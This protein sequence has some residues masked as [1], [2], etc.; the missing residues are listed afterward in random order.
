MNIVLINDNAHING[1]AAKIAIMNAFDL[2]GRGHSVFFLCALMP[3]ATELIHPNIK[4]ICTE[5]YEILSDP[6]RFRASAQGWW[7]FKA[8]SVADEVFDSLKASETVV[9]LHTW[10]KA[11]SSSVIRAAIKRGFPIVCTL[12]DFMLACPTGTLFNHPKQEICRLTPMSTACLGTQCDARS[13]SQKLWRVGRQLIQEKV[14]HLPRGISNFIVHSELVSDVMRPH[15][16][17]NSTIHPVP[18]YFQGVKR[19]PSSP[20]DNETFTYLGRLVREKGV[21]MLARSAAAE[22]VPLT[23]V[24]SGEMADVVRAIYPGAPVTGWMSREESVMYLRSSRAL[25]FPSLWYETLGL[26]VLEASANGIPSIVPRSSAAA[27]L[28]MDGETGLHFN[29]GDEDDLRSKIRMLK[30]PQ[31][32]SRLGKAAYEAFWS[33]RSSRR[34]AHL[35]SLEAVYRKALGR[36]CVSEEDKV[37]LWESS[38]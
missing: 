25:V 38:R 19:E 2:A 22:R 30:N 31:L 26:V 12:H 24:G 9:H 10:A 16:P 3:V 13:Y 33:G 14:G 21:A 7:N 17:K 20:A 4:V 11:L 18:S 1:G 34:G 32:A 15:L 35:D 36:D 5:Q 37:C 28:V 23:F 6:N 29:S 27:E 8:G